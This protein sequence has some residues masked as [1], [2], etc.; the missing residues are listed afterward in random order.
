MYEIKSLNLKSNISANDSARIISLKERL[1]L[2]KS[3]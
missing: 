1:N 3:D 2:F